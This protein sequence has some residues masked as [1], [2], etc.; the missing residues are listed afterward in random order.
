MTGN[1]SL[2]PPAQNDDAT[3]EV[4]VVI[5]GAGPVGLLLA[6]GLARRQIRVLVLEKEPATAEHSRAPAIWPAA[7]ELLLKFGVLDEFLR[8][9]I[10]LPELRL[11]DVDR[12]RPLLRLPV[13]E[14]A[15]ETTCAQMLIVPQSTTERLLHEAVAR[16]STG[17][18]RFS[19]EVTSIKQ[20][21]SSV[22]VVYREGDGDAIVRAQLVA[23]CDGAGSM[24]REQIG[25]S[26]EGI[27]Y[28][29][30]AA[31]ADVRASGLDDLPFPRL[32]SRP[33]LA[34][35]IRI[36]PDLWRLILP[37]VPGREKRLLDDRIDDAVRNL[38]PKVD[39]ETTWKSEF[40]LHRRVSSIWI[41][42]RVVLAGD[43]AH[44]NSPV[45]GEG[46]NAGMLDAGLLT[47]AVIEALEKDDCAP[48]HVYV[49]RRRHAIEQGVNRFTDVMTRLF[50]TGG[51]RL[52]RPMMRIV[53]IVLMIRPLRR[54]LMRKLAMLDAA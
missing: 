28:G 12:E 25:G 21:P 33:T 16:T 36:G 1:D 51:G 46:M 30:E 24:V 4:D 45:G 11:W 18:V 26:L 2:I 31:L 52:A 44:L 40:R 9:G 39:Y 41:D 22:D 37:F 35:G 7:Q 50:L 47:E 5:V 42:R 6:L 13:K 19:S 49:T 38:F 23:G 27:T 20:N 29:V 17:E 53:S 15:D 34:V 3:E 8:I 48:L 43:A 54:R 14:L 10:A 32:T